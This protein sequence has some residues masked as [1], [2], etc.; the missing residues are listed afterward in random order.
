MRKPAQAHSFKTLS[1]SS[2]F[3]FNKLFI[4]IIFHI[5]SFCQYVMIKILKLQTGINIGQ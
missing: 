1:L 2:A 3:F 4:V 5:L